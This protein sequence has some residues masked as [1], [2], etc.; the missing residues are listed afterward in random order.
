M[1]EVDATEPE[2]FGKMIQRLREARGMSQERL[3]ALA[4]Y[5]PGNGMV[6]Q[7]EGGTRGARLPRDRLVAFAQALGVPVTDML[8]A[9][10]KLTAKEASEIAKRPAFADFVNSDPNLRVDQKRMLVALYRTY[11]PKDPG[12]GGGSGG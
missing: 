2:S 10:G 5:V 9:A 3:E 8:R 11:V 6:S 7:I 4:G 1:T 12:A